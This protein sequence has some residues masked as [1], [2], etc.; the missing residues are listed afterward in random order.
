MKKT[1]FNI[2]CPEWMGN[3]LGVVVK[4]V[5]GCVMYFSDYYWGIHKSENENKFSASELTTGFAMPDSYGKTIEET[6]S[7]LKRAVK[8]RR[9]KM[10]KAITETKKYLKKKGIKFPVNNVKQLQSI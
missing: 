4:K 7:L 1:E 9:E 3:E 10:P 2:S 6:I 5:K 8:K